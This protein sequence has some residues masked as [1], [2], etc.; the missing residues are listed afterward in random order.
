MPGSSPG[1]DDSI[2]C[3]PFLL[4]QRGGGGLSNG[5]ATRLRSAPRLIP[6]ERAPRRRARQPGLGRPRLPPCDRRLEPLQPLQAHR[7]FRAAA[8]LP[9]GPARQHDRD[10]ARKGPAPQ[11]SHLL[12]LQRDARA[13]QGDARSHRRAR[14]RPAGRR[15]PHLHLHLHHGELPARRGA[16]RRTGHR[17]RPPE[18]NRRRPSRRADARAGV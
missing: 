4:A 11:Y 13:G 14:H 1:H 15:R 12:A 6:P 5:H 16:S 17:L 3:R 8:R 18:P 7:N 2:F 10:A 9:L